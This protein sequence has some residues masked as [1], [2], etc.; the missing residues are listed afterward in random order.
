KE[1]SSKEIKKKNKMFNIL[2]LL[3]IISIGLGFIIPLMY[4]LLIPFIIGLVYT[5][6]SKGNI[7]KEEE[8]FQDQISEVQN[9]NEEKDKKIQKINK[10]LERLLS[11]YHCK[12]RKELK[13][14]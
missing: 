1:E 9:L 2:L 7:I 12:T 10:E 5:R 13:Q 6:I 3:S 8:K 4:I 11:K 14:L